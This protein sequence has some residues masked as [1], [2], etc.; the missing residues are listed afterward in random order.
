MYDEKIKLL[1]SYIDE[2]TNCLQIGSEK[3][4]QEI[5]DEFIAVFSGEIPAIIRGLKSREYGS[6]GHPYLEDIE[7]VRRK[8][9][10]HKTDVKKAADDK[11]YDLKI[12]E[13]KSTKISNS[14]TQ[15]MSVNISLEQVC[16]AIEEEQKDNRLSKEDVEKLQDLLGQVELAKAKK[17]GVW[18]KVKPA[19]AFLLDKGADALIAAGPYLLNA[20]KSIS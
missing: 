4:A 2:C 12:A 20:L 5:I 15:S 9:E 16:R 10:K 17:K 11:E 13:A 3:K 8:L 1:D 14:N 18:E 7:I 19:F 6:D